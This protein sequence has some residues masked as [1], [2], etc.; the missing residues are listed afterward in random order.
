MIAAKG[1]QRRTELERDAELEHNAEAPK[2]PAQRSSDS[3]VAAVEIRGVMEDTFARVYGEM[4]PSMHVRNKK[5][6]LSLEIKEEAYILLLTMIVGHD[7]FQPRH[8]LTIR[9]AEISD[10]AMFCKEHR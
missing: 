7:D 1:K 2:K 8:G 3:R 9:E 5:D 10:S 6:E 4:Y